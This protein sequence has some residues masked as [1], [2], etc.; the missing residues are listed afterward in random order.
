M[1]H[2]MSFFSSDDPVP[3]AI[4]SHPLNELP[5][6]TAH[7]YPPASGTLASP[8]ISSNKECLMELD[9]PWQS[10][11]RV[12][13]DNEQRLNKVL[14]K[15]V[16]QLFKLREDVR[17]LHFSNHNLLLW[18]RNTQ[19]TSNVRESDMQLTIVQ[20]QQQNQSLQCDNANALASLDQNHRKEVAELQSNMALGLHKAQNEGHAEI[21]NL[22]VEKEVQ[23]EHEMHLARDRFLADNEAELT[24]LDAKYSSKINLLDDFMSKTDFR[25]SLGPSKDINALTL[26]SDA[27]SLKHKIDFGDLVTPRKR[28]VLESYSTGD[29][30]QV[31][32]V[33]SD[34]TISTLSH[35]LESIPHKLIKYITLFW[36]FDILTSPVLSQ[37]IALLENICPSG[38]EE[39]TCMGFC[40]GTVSPS[41]TGLT[42][43]QACI[44]ANNLK[45]FEASSRAFFSPKIVPFTIQTIRLSPCLEK[46]RLSSVKLSAAHWDKLMHHFTIPTLVELR[47]DADCAPPT[48]IHFLVRQPAVS[49]LSVI[50]RPAGVPWRANRVTKPFI[51]SLSTLDGPLSHLLPILQSHRKQQNLTC[52]HISLQAH[53]ASPD[54]ITSILQCVGHCDSIG[55][56]LLSLPNSHS[57]A[58]MMCWSGTRSMVR[59]KH[60]VI[61]CSDGSARCATSDLLALSAAWI[62]A[63]P[64]VKCVTL[65][66][67][68]A[69]AAGIL[70][71]LCVALLQAMSNWLWICRSHQTATANSG[72]PCAEV[73]QE[74]GQAYHSLDSAATFTV[75]DT[76]HIAQA[77]QAAEKRHCSKAQE[78]LD[79]VESQMDRACSQ[80]F[81][82]TSHDVMQTIQDELAVITMALRNVKYKIHEAH[83]FD[84]PIDLCDEVAQISLFLGAVS[85]VIF[86]I[87]R[88]HG[89]FFMGVL[90]LILGL[91]MEAQN[92]HSESHRQNT[93]SQ[94]PRS[95]ET[96]LSHFKLD[97][98]TTAYA[99]SQLTPA[100]HKSDVVPAFEH[101]FLDVNSHKPP[102]FNEKD[103]RAVQSIHSLLTEAVPDLEGSDPELIEDHIVDLER[104]L[105]TKK[106]ACLQFV[107]VG[108][109]IKPEVMHPGKK[110]YKIHWVRLLL[111]WVGISIVLFSY[112][113]N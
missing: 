48:L 40:D 82:A 73:Q 6:T 65:Q 78:A 22:L 89:E 76:Q 32:V 55:Y 38:V 20:Y 33:Y 74:K 14:L 81:S 99:V 49:N 25:G 101:P 79:V 34:I 10:V 102:E 110:V 97:G 104:R 36:N 75:D 52:L 4:E 45:A 112:P 7:T 91:A 8:V 41:I 9:N 88:R 67:Y 3:E 87:S 50:P 11:H 109:G 35:F 61:D 24:R 56:L 12:R 59:I 85:V 64:Q 18:K 111:A 95:M 63:L 107:S 68:S 113:L 58:V 96:A 62:Q 100:N 77:L 103:I 15:E 2:L 47:V 60:L 69:T 86:G 23:F 42:R 17:E 66:G 80:I 16:D 90:A 39:L 37:M 30:C 31:V 84:L 29:M 108:L 28:C 43:I 93:L 21:E 26:E 72:I 92:P 5:P 1:S 70:S 98:Q 53:D 19:V 13:D 27:P 105:L 51:L 57:S 54:Y 71:T 46:L 44:G 94:I 83:H 106:V